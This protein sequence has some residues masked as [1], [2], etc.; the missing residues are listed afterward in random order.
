MIEGKKTAMITF[1]AEI[2]QTFLGGNHINSTRDMPKTSSANNSIS[3]MDRTIAAVKQ[4]QAK[5][6]K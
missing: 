4:L 6:R 5:Q 3:P 2:A 1:I